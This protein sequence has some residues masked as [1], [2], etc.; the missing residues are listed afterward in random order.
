MF[1][2]YGC[3]DMMKSAR[4]SA[5]DETLNYKN[6]RLKNGVALNIIEMRN[7]IIM[8]G[9]SLEWHLVVFERRF[10]ESNKSSDWYLEINKA[11]NKCN[12]INFYERMFLKF[13]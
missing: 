10:F 1:D 5:F 6:Y 13:F 12:S 11:F 3:D 7:P 4:R 8:S 9:G 2:I